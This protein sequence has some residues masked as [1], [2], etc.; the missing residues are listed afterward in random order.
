MKSLKG[1]LKRWNTEAFGNVA[2]KKLEA[3]SQVELWDSKEA[4]GTLSFEEE[5]TRESSRVEFKKWALMEE[6]S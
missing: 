2:V 6:T 1:L 4:Q 3:L 5:S